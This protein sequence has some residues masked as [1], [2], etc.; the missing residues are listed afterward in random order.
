MYV[1]VCSVHHFEVKRSCEPG[2]KEAPEQDSE[3]ELLTSGETAVGWL[4]CRPLPPWRREAWPRGSWERG[5]RLHSLAALHLYFSYRKWEV[6]SSLRKIPRDLSWLI[7][8]KMSRAARWFFQGSFSA[9]W[10]NESKVPLKG[11][12]RFPTFVTLLFPG[13]GGPAWP[14]SWT[15]GTVDASRVFEGMKCQS[16]DH[17]APSK[18][19]FPEGLP[20]P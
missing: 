14:L 7:I 13:S 6:T 18:N 11:P 10:V 5:P 3:P 2:W 15:Q 12:S 9:G 20:F 16:E 17:W 4:G 1:C 8:W 19:T